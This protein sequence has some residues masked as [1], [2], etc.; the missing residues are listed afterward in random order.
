MRFGSPPRAWG[1]PWGRAM[2][3]TRNAVHP[4][5]RGDDIASP[6]AA[7]TVNGSPPRA[8]G[9][10]VDAIQRLLPLRFTPTCVG[11]T[12]ITASVC[13]MISVHPHVRGDDRNAHMSA[14]SEDG[15]P[16]RAWGRHRFGEVVD[17]GLR[18][19]P[20][21]V[22]TTGRAAPACT[23]PSVHPHVRGD[24]ALI[25]ACSA[26]ST[27]SPPRAWGRPAADPVRA[28]AGRFTPTCVGTTCASSISRTLVTVHPHVRGDD[29]ARSLPAAL[30]AGSP[31]RAWGRRCRSQPTRPQGRFTPT[32]VGTTG[33]SRWSA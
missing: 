20:T 29:F 13:A 27:G 11:T 15:S 17:P 18:F 25:L 12:R 30:L 33:S 24:D 7:S 16:P 2:S 5:V 14:Y 26:T 21:C 19:T 23:G 4:H 9:R 31:P 6:L 10:L 1:R 32:C 28:A 22:G 8:W 3:D